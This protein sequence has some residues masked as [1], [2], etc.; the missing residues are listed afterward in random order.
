MNE[1][2]GEY[3]FMG[4]WRFFDKEK[5]MNAQRVLVTNGDSIII[6]SMTL[7]EGQMYWT[8]DRGSMEGYHPVAWMELPSLTVFNNYEMGIYKNT[9]IS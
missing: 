4:H 6:G 3:T 9:T 2:I 8:F 5:P 7:Q 1:N